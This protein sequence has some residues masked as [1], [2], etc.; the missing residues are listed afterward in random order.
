VSAEKPVTAEEAKSLLAGCPGWTMAADGKSI[1]RTFVM[2]GFSAAAE[3]I[4]LIA[5]E[6]DALDHHPDL[7]L[8]GYRKLEI[9]LTTHK[10]GGLSDKDFQLAGRID[11]LPKKLKPA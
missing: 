4:A 1:A 5:A 9:L 11:A 10:T 3:L 7:H 8:T 6:A 2:A